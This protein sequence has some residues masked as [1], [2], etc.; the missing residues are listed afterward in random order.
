[1]RPFVFFG[2][3]C[4]SRSNLNGTSEP[5]PGRSNLNSRLVLDRGVSGR[6]EGQL[7]PAVRKI[8]PAGGRVQ[9]SNRGGDSVS[10][11]IEFSAN[12]GSVSERLRHAGDGPP[13]TISAADCWDRE[14]PRRA[15]SRRADRPVSSLRVRRPAPRTPVRRMRRRCSGARHGRRRR[16]W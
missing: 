10:G 1:M 12:S 2:E 15:P 11:M 8:R 4:R 5:N 6:C 3:A 16:S 13:I 7:A 9:L 14:A